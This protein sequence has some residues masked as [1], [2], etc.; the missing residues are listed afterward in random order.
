MIV[1]YPYVVEKVWILIPECKELLS[2]ILTREPLIG[3]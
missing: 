1:A 2:L 3:V